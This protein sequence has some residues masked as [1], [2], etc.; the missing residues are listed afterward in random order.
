MGFS[1]GFKGLSLC[2]VYNNFTAPQMKKDAPYTEVSK[3]QI[4]TPVCMKTLQQNI[5]S[6]HIPHIM[7][8]LRS[9]ASYYK[10]HDASVR[11]SNRIPGH[12]HLRI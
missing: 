1:S 3:R 4:L 5:P 2:F 8:N 12:F 9:N 11:M 7:N 10:E 6:F